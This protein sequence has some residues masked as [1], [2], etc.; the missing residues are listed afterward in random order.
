M[1]LHQKEQLH[2]NTL[3]MMQ[4][5]H[6]SIGRS[7]GFNL[8]EAY[9][10]Y[11]PQQQQ[12]HAPTVSSGVSFASVNNQDLHGSELFQSSH[13]AYHPQTSGPPG[14][15]LRPLNSPNTVSNVGSYDQLIQQYQHQNQPQFRLQQMSS[16]NQPFRDQGIKPMQIAQSAPD[17]FG[18]LGLLSVIRMSDPDLTS[19]ALGIDLTTLGLNLNST[20]NLNKTFGSPWSDEP[21]KGDPE[22]NVPKCYY[23][24]PPPPLDHNY[25]SKFWTETL[26]YAFY[27]CS[28]LVGFCCF[29]FLCF[30]F[31]LMPFFMHFSMPKDEAQLHAANILYERGWL[32]HK[33]QRRWLKR[34]PNTEPLVKTSTYERASYHCFEPS[35]FEITLKENFVLHYEMVE[36]R[37]GLPQH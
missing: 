28:C 17:P 26:L 31:S 10:S 12:Q 19:L 15:G 30:K 27:R 16:V 6:F 22:F 24:K 37:P 36:K 18:L 3:S 21:A 34:V 4:S 5:Q 20:E 11:R 23:A 25:F 7:A 33:E 8:G 32:Y 14:I 35:T 13:S 1:D 9:S 2:D 29:L